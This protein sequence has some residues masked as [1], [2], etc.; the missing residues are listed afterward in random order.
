MT[1][2]RVLICAGILLFLAGCNA[3]TNPPY[4]NAVYTTV[5]EIDGCEYLKSTDYY[6]AHY[7]LCHKGNCSNPIHKGQV[8]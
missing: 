2:I 5:I 1:K 3:P 6:E 8:R 7:N 4:A